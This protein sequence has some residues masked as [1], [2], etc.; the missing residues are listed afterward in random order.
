MR[1][2]I[3]KKSTKYSLYDGAAFAV[4][5]GMTAS[6]ITPFA[7]A[8]NAS[9]SLIAAL[10]YVPQLVGAFAQLFAA[11]LVEIIQNRR[12]ILVIGSFLHA[13]LWIPLLL[14]PY[15]SPSIMFL[16]V[17]YFSLLTNIL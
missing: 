13:L 5:D 15:T 11:K 12:R 2:D 16:L 7:I 1:E 3:S 9:V 10:T 17:V 8:L 14:I 4:M 6:F